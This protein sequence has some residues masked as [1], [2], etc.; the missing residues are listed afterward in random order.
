[1]RLCF[2]CWC[3]L[4]VGLYGQSTSAE[5]TTLIDQ[6]L[7]PAKVIALTVGRGQ[8]LQFSQDIIRVVV[9]EPKVADAIVVSPREV[10]VAAKGA[11]K[12]TLASWEGTGSP[13]RFDI[14]VHA[15]QDEANKHKARRKESKVS[16]H[17]NG[18]P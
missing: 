5:T 17:F 9:A 1:M 15:D 2:S 16:F 7:Q 12:T 13:A 3:F 6:P 10:M 18:S 8:L 14:N 4:V 11:G